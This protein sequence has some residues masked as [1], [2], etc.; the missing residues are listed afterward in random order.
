MLAPSWRSSCPSP[1]PARP[2]PPMPG[3]ADCPKTS[4][5]SSSPRTTPSRP[6]RWP[7]AAS[8]TSTSACRRTAPSRARR[9][10]TRPRASRTA[11]RSPRGSAGEK[12]TRNA[13]T[14]LN[15][16]FF[17]FQFWDG[18]AASLEEQAKGPMVN[19]VEMGMASHDD[20][21]KVVRGVPEY[22]AAFKAVFGREPTIDGHRRRHRHLRAHGG[23]RQLPLRPLHGRRQGRDVRLGAARL[24]ALER[25]GPLQYLPPVRQRHAELLGQQLPQHRR[26][27]EGPRLRRA[28]PPGRAGDRSPEARVPRRLQRARPL[29]RRRSSPRTSAPSRP[30]ACATSRC[31]PPTCTTAAR[32]RSSTS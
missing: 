21:V 31:R 17:E 11:R 22:A 8:S 10:T 16:I 5:R 23:H 28:R 30:R 12:G 7:S 3:R 14:V 15:A 19:P 18:R 1:S 26:R 2:G 13:P 20:V 24:G 4:G 6:R 32:R 9:A 29:R 25:Q 27:G